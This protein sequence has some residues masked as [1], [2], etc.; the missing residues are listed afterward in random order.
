MLFVIALAG[1]SL[2]VA[3]PHADILGFFL[4][5]NYFIYIMNGFVYCKDTDNMAILCKCPKCSPGVA[6]PSQKEDD[7]E[8]NSGTGRRRDS[9][10]HTS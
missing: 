6:E 9:R 7:D 8:A 3:R 2:A 4:Q 1:V 5:I 10:S